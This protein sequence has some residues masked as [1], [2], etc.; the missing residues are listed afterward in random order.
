MR[1]TIAS[2]F[3]ELLETFCEYIAMNLCRSLGQDMPMPCI[4]RFTSHYFSSADTA[5]SQSHSCGIWHPW[6]I[7]DDREKRMQRHWGTIV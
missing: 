1:C 6:W 2:L 4:K 7:V 5:I 3:Q